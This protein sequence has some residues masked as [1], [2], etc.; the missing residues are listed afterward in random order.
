MMTT[1]ANISL[2]A[3]AAIA[4]CGMTRLDALALQRCSF[5]PGRYYAW[6][7][8]KGD[9]TST[10]RLIVL[11]V[12]IACFTTMAQVSWMVVMLLA[13][14]L[15]A[16]GVTLLTTKREPPTKLTRGAALVWAIS[17]LIA[18][19]AV[20]AIGCM[21]Y[22]SGEADWLHPA[23]LAAVMAAAVSPLFTILTGW[24]LKPDPEKGETGPE[25]QLD[26]N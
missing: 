5:K 22:Y 25:D 2:L 9:L 21:A 10:K 13:L 3:A 15:L 23:A 4:L 1:I 26:N 16:L 24:L 7:T 6:L 11:A 20:A 8:Q 18:M 19:L 17:C 14:A 12:L